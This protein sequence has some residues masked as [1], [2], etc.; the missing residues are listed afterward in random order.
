M[1]SSLKMM[2][3]MHVVHEGATQMTENKRDHG[4]QD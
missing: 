2:R 3:V 4:D 1:A